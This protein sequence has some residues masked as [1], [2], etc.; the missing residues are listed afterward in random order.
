MQKK[1]LK[2]ESNQEEESEQTMDITLYKNSM[3]VFI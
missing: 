3:Y 1:T 2:L